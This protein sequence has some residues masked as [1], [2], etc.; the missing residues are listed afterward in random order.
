MISYLSQ[1]V[2]D[3]RATFVRLV[4]GE[5]Q[6]F[7]YAVEASGL[8]TSWKPTSLV[9][10]TMK[11]PLMFGSM[12]EATEFRKFL[13]R[14]RGQHLAFWA[15]A[16]ISVFEIVGWPVAGATVLTVRKCDFSTKWAVGNQFR[17]IAVLSP[18]H[19]ACH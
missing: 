12:T 14:I 17:H 8:A 15:P 6:D 9:K 7:S 10:R 4:S 11:L 1:E 2:L 16:Y 5:A 3:V 18:K 13:D 19:F